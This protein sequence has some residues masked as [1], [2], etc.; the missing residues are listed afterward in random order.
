MLF[1]HA[2]PLLSTVFLK[3]WANEVSDLLRDVVRGQV[4]DELPVMNPFQYYFMSSCVSSNLRVLFFFLMA[5]P[6]HFV[7]STAM[8]QLS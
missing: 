7:L 2:G 8:S 3:A 1:R 4:A 6:L 5:S